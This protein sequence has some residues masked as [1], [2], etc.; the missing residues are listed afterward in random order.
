MQIVSMSYVNIQN[1]RFRTKNVLVK[2]LLVL[3]IGKEV[4]KAMRR[5][6]ELTS[7]TSFTQF[8]Q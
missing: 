2:H 4:V 5:H 1:L 7:H 8:S 6:N 3:K